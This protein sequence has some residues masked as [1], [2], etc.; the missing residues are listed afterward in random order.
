MNF[1]ILLFNVLTK[2]YFAAKQIRVLFEARSKHKR[3]LAKI[4]YKK[5]VWGISSHRDQ[6][7]VCIVGKD[8]SQQGGNGLCGRSRQ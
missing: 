1:L 3:V 6:E 2:L 7:D 5:G 8:A 4:I